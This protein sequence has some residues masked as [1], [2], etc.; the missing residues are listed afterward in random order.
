MVLKDEISQVNL[1]VKHSAVGPLSQTVQAIDSL[2]QGKIVELDK[3]SQL[4]PETKRFITEYLS[5]E[6]LPTPVKT[7]VMCVLETLLTLPSPKDQAAYLKRITPI[8]E[9][10]I[11]GVAPE[12]RLKTADDA[13]VHEAIIGLANTGNNAD[14]YMI[15]WMDF[16]R[17]ASRQKGQTDLIN[18]TLESCI[19]QE[20]WRSVATFLAEP[21]NQVGR[22]KQVQELLAGIEQQ[23]HDTNANKFY[24]HY[25]ITSA[26][27]FFSKEVNRNLDPE[28]FSDLVKEV[29]LLTE[30][31]SDFSDELFLR[32]ISNFLKIDNNLQVFGTW[33]DKI[34]QS[35]NAFYA[36]TGDFFDDPKTWMG[37]EQTAIELRQAAIGGNQWQDVLKHFTNP[38]VPRP[39]TLPG[40]EK[41]S[42]DLLKIAARKSK[43]SQLYPENRMRF[44]AHPENLTDDVNQQDILEEIEA[45]LRAGDDYGYMVALSYF[46]ELSTEPISSSSQTE[47][48]LKAVNR[49]SDKSLRGKALNILRMYMSDL[50]LP[51]TLLESLPVDQIPVTVAFKILGI[52]ESVVRSWQLTEENLA[53]LLPSLIR[54]VEK[55]E[56]NKIFAGI[57]LPFIPRS[58]EQ[59]RAVLVENIIDWINKLDFLINLPKEL[60]GIEIIQAHLTKISALQQKLEITATTPKVSLAALRQV[61][62]EIN[63]MGEQLVEK[64]SLLLQLAE[65]LSFEDFEA[66]VKSWGGEITSIIM[67]GVHYGKNYKEGLTFLGKK[68]T[69]IIDGVSISSRYD[70]ADQLTRHQLSPLLQDQEPEM[71]PAIIKTWRDP[72]Y[73]LAIETSETIATSTVDDSAALNKITQELGQRATSRGHFHAQN[74]QTLIAKENSL[75]SASNIISLMLD[76]LSTSTQ[77]EPKN[78]IGLLV[79][80]LK[81]TNLTADQQVCVIGLANFFRELKIGRSKV[82]DLISTITKLVKKINLVWPE[83]AESDLINQDL[84]VYTLNE[85]TAIETKVTT[86]HSTKLFL[87][88]VTDNPKTLLEIG[89]YPNSGSCQNYESTGTFNQGL[90]GYVFDAHIQAACVAEIELPQI[91][92]PRIKELSEAKIAEVNLDL[93]KANLVLPTGEI[94]SIKISKPIARRM[95]MLG[96]AKSNQTTSSNSAIALVEEQTYSDAGLDTSKIDMMLNKT[97]QT[98]RNQLA[99]QLTQPVLNNTE[100]AAE[101]YVTTIAGSHNPAGHYNDLGKGLSGSASEDYTINRYQS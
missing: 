57:V 24:P 31:P 97:I 52:P 100:L 49:I 14:N 55:P 70:V 63:Q 51:Q 4:A 91:L 43:E 67:L 82:P 5:S 30:D 18:S 58:N 36:V 45:R 47:L 29:N 9:Q 10:T 50:S 62:L 93:G 98:K 26:L 22:T 48:F 2:T 6:D 41:Y 11:S 54:L 3:A 33:A 60:G 99:K 46:D 34:C 64:L 92:E 35:S 23:K 84:A 85:L 44:F 56:L 27:I 95:I 39:G 59:G 37:R 81:K 32:S 80:E 101:K 79:Q 90:L 73:D 13:K 38:K 68:I 87:N 74:L 17:S 66:F 8:L 1:T 78:Q 94:F 53:S 42:K 12:N 86:Q 15:I 88:F 28:L 19:G 7:E 16:F 75:D 21:A 76:S 69:E 20:N 71:V 77:E 61:K 89:R 65:K 72:Q 83:L 96:E 40:E 25:W